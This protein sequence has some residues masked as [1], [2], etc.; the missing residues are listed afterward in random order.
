MLIRVQKPPKEAEAPDA[1][2]E[3]LNDPMD[4]SDKLY[5]IESIVDTKRS[6]SCSARNV[7]FRTIRLRGTGVSLPLN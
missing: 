7:C 5:D 3:V 6:A 1:L 4:I 2:A